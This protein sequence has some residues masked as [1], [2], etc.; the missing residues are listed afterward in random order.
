MV[1][2]PLRDASPAHAPERAGGSPRLY[3]L[4]ALSI[5]VLAGIAVGAG[6]LIRGMRDNA[7][8]EGRTEDP[9]PI[10]IE[11]GGVRL[12][13]PA[14]MIRF[15]AQ[16]WDGP[17]ERVDLRLGWPDLNGFSLAREQAQTPVPDSAPAL[18]VTLSAADPDAVPMEEVYRLFLTP[19]G[20]DGPAG[21]TGVRLAEGSAYAGEELYYQ[22]RVAAPFMARC[23]P[24]GDPDIPP[25][26]LRQFERAGLS[27][28]Y[29]FDKA[30]LPEWRALDPAVAA[31]VDG[32]I[33]R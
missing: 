5:M 29:R 23:L 17:A 9:T 33:R 22:A 10:A 27:V 20:W 11:I 7:A 13:I 3:V 12:A 21:L 4:L 31:R 15:A 1:N 2:V 14:N 6:T 26:C 8:M 25:T 24:E 16:R 19:G 30:L 28:L 32:F 18:F